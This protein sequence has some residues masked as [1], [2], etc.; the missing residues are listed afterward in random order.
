MRNEI[1]NISSGFEQSNKDTVKRII[2]SYFLDQPVDW[3]DHV[4]L[5]HTRKGQD[6]R[7]GIDNSKLVS[8][9]WRPKKVFEKEINNIV[10]FYKKRFY[11]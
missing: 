7:Y 9:G 10:K 1:F 2:N 8:L 3:K 4:D 6:V 11:W 5:S